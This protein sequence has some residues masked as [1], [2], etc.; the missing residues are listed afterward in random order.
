MTKGYQTP[1][2]FGTSNPKQKRRSNTG[3]FIVLVVL[4]LVGSGLF[5][6]AFLAPASLALA[7]EQA[8]A[9]LHGGIAERT[10]V[11][12]FICTQPGEGGPQGVTRTTRTTRFADGTSLTVTF[13]ARPVL[14]SNC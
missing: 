6:V 13:E 5:G 12:A 8:L 11:P 14:A 9:L 7:Q 3:V 1:I 10:E 2:G 4:L